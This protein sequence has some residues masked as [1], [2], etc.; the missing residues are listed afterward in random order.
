MCSRRDTV[1]IKGF[2]QGLF[3]SFFFFFVLDLMSVKKKK[4]HETRCQ[5]LILTCKTNEEKRPCRTR[6]NDVD[7]SILQCSEKC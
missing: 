3:V 1:M 5:P 2:E 4:Q 7:M 6:S